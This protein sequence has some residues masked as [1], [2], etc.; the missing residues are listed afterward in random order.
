M[1]FDITDPFKGTGLKGIGY[2]A[3]KGTEDWFDKN[4][5]LRLTPDMPGLPQFG[6]G[7]AGKRARDYSQIV[8]ALQRRMLKTIT[9]KGRAATIA[10]SP[11][12]LE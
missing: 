9:G 11:R 6:G 12:G 3:Y 1:A 7:K 5:N 4:F 10:T 2:K 8:Q